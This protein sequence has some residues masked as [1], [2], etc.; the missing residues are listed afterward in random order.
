MAINKK[1]LVFLL[2]DGWG[3][4]SGIDNNAIRKADIPGFKNLVSNYPST[5]ITPPGL[6]ASKNYRL[7]GLGKSN[8]KENVANLS[9]SRLI[10]RSNLSQLKIANSQDLPLLSVF[11]NNSEERPLNEDWIIF[12]DE[13]DNIWS[14]L[15]KNNLSD[16]LIKQIK[17]GRYNFIASSLPYISQVLPEGD[18]TKMVSAVE[19]TSR[20]L[21][22]IAK[23]VLSVDGTLVVSSVYGGAE[24]VFSMGT[25]LPNKKRSTNPVPFIIINQKYKGRVIDSGEA[26]NNDISLLSPGGSYLDI[27]PTILK[28]L[29]LRIPEEMEGRSLIQ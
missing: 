8:I 4:S 9:L 26:P 5:V 12:D 13:P 17:S 14:F 20:C 24:D 1:L 6:Q 11:L 19:N 3:A 10:S 25:G 21:E 16:R 28:L 15:F 23:A 29:E 2:I 7:V 18:F 22:K 27:S